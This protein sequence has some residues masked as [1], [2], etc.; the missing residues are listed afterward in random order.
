METEKDNEPLSAV[1]HLVGVFLAV[2][3]LVLLI[4]TAS[5]N[6]EAAHVVGYTIFGVTMFILYL[7]SAIYHFISRSSVKLKAVF[8]VF[9]HIS[10]YLL[11]AGTYTPITIAVL[12]PAWGWSIF[13]VIWGI[14]ILGIVIK[15]TK[16]K[17]PGWSS[18][19]LYLIMGWLILIAYRPLIQSLNEDALFWLVVGGV[20]YTVGILF[21]LL[22][23][24]TPRTRWFG[25]H[26][27]FHVLVMLGSFSHFWMLYRY[28]M[29]ILL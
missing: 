16:L 5:L 19:L 3:A 26:E 15:A 2:V 14:A 24:F 9:D 28:I 12:P 17:I 6:G 18:A 8:Q 10:I 25:T 27:V 22:D 1:T 21:F 20:F 29:K 7:M 4:V 23:R 13:G 11:I